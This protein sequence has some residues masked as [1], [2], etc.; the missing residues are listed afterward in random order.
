MYSIDTLHDKM[1]KSRFLLLHSTNYII[2]EHINQSS[3]SKIFSNLCVGQIY[4]AL[5]W[6]IIHENIQV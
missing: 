2:T 1:S 5:T 6:E 3:A 4:V